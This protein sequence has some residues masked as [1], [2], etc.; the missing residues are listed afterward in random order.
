MIKSLIIFF[1][2]LAVGV[3]AVAVIQNQSGKSYSS[4][5]S[6]SAVLNQRP[7]SSVQSGIVRNLG[8]QETITRVEYCEGKCRC[9]R[10]NV[11]ETVARAGIIS[12]SKAYDVGPNPAARCP[13]I[14][15]THNRAPVP[16]ASG[17]CYVCPQG[18]SLSTY[19]RGGDD[20][21][22]RWNYSEPVCVTVNKVCSQ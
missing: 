5:Y 17:Q 1:I 16:G 7:T 19:L 11:T 9:D 20:V 21:A 2:A 8:P 18:M 3:T 14:N 4:S 10:Y 12:A 22:R 15:G 6:Q 13:G